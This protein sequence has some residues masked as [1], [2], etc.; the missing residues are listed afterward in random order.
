M[1]IMQW[2]AL[3]ALAAMAGCTDD[4]HVSE[5]APEAT[6][7]PEASGTVQ[8]KLTGVDSAGRT[9]RLRDASFQ[10]VGYPYFGGV[11]LPGM[12]YPDDAGVGTLSEL[13]LSTEDN[14]DLPVLSAHVIPGQ[15]TVS[16]L[17]T[18]WYLERTADSGW[19]RV[20]QSVLLSDATQ[21]A[22][23]WNGGITPVNF[24]FGV[25]GELIDFR[26][27]DIQIGITIE[28]PGDADAGLPWPYDGGMV[29]YD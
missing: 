14:P 28:R 6:A 21:F 18:A 10:V 9:Y 16:L 11:L 3:S 20:E 26:A 15:Y 8:L 2:A 25:D 12:P 27:G 1:K 13:Y 7:A 4:A 19:E 29:R 22:Y 24:A 17:G 23:V 5:A